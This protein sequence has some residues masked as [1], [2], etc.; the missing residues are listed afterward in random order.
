LLIFQLLGPGGAGAQPLVLGANVN[1][2]ALAGAQ[3]EVGIAVNPTNPLNLVAVSNHIANLSRLGVWF[4]L[5][6]GTTWT[7]N[8][9]TQTQDGFGAGDSRFDPNVAFDSDGN[10]YVV[11]STTGSGNRIV[12]ARSTN[13]GQLFNQVT[14]V[15]TDAGPNNMHTA[16]VT[17]RSDVAGADDVLVA[18]ARVQAAGER[19]QAA[20]SLDAG[21]TFPTTNT[22]IN[23]A[24]QRTFLPWAAV[25]NAGNFHVVWEVNTGGGAGT[26]FHD[27]LNGTTLASG[28]DVTVTGVQI[29]DFAAAT[30][31]IPAQPDR[32]V[33]SVSTIDVNRTSGRIFVSYTDRT[34][35]ATNDTN[36]FVRFSD[37]GGANW[38]VATQ[39]N[40]DATTTSQF[41]PRLA[42]DQLNQV[43]YLTWYDARNDA[44]N[45]Q[46]T[47]VFISTGVD[48]ITW[49]AN[50][51]LTTAASNES[52]TNAARDGNNY[53]EYFGLIAHKC[54]AYAVWTDGRAANFTGGT[55]ED[56]YT[57]RSILDAVAPVI[58]NVPGPIQAEQTSLAGT[59]VIVPLPT[60]ADNCDDN[61]IITSNAPAVF[62]LGTTTVTFTATDDAGNSSTATT[63][64][65]IVDTTQPTID[66]VSASPS[67]LWPPNH[68]LKPVLVS[69]NVSD[70][71]DAHLD[72]VIIS[73]SSNEPINGLG[74]GNTA[75]DW[76]ITGN[77]T[78]NLRAERSGTGDGRVYT[79]TVRCT[80]E[81]GNSSTRAVQVT[82]AHDQG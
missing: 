77:L 76:V 49:T 51:R 73:V 2:S 8:F 35:T 17:T 37:N 36:V 81:S 22:A 58:G 44:T 69:V 56:V 12:L 57:A 19:I 32:G 70:I 52:T 42:I 4:S 29:T 63:T 13:G 25:D 1:V 33:F 46:Q 9:I 20:L 45:N 6:G 18:W 43:V 28:A 65:T 75:P 68:K 40:T 31:R 23:D 15:T 47:D 60:A 72:C 67:T 66:S 7:A 41:L 79:I 54:I 16:M 34:S 50:Q 71:C 53:G 80:D 82:V 74:D 3:S 62:P 59:P 10:V 39:V 61:V 11:Y 55:N 21:A 30:S 14:T 38:S 78:V 27:T 48:G 5:N 64:V 24:Q 26:I